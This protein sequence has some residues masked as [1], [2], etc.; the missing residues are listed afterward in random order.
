[1]AVNAAGKVRVR[2]PPS[3]TG[4]LHLG[5]ARTALF[6]W[7][8]ARKNGGEFIFRIED[9]DRERS[10]K[11]YEDQIIGSLN[12]LG[13]DWD[14]GIGKEKRDTKYRQSERTEIYRK[15]LEQ[16]LAE[17][18]AYYCY[19]SKEDLDAEK[20]AAEA[21]GRAW[22]YSGRCRDLKESPAGKEPQIIRLKV[23]EKTV[24]FHDLIRGMVKTDVTPLGDFVIAKNLDTALYNL[25]VTVDDHDM[26]VT[27]VIRGEDHI[28]NTPKQIVI[29]ESLGLNIPEYAHL[30]LVLNPDRSKLSKRFADVNVL[31][32]RDQ[33]YL[34]DA[35]LNY[36]VLLGWHPQDDREIFTL[37]ELVQEFDISRVQKSG[38]IWND[39]KLAWINKEHIKKLSTE[40]LATMLDTH[41]KEHKGRSKEFIH[42]VID[43]TRDRMHTLNDFWNYADFFFE[44]PDY[45]PELLIWKKGSRDE[46]KAVLGALGAIFTDLTAYDAK[47]L[48]EKLVP[49]VTQYGKGNVLWPLRA[50]LSGKEASPDPYTIATVLGQEKSLSRLETAIKKLA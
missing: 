10:K 20:A 36:L 13:L 38:A 1:M 30:P 47:L 29:A 9:T 18:K 2:F 4:F 34:P 31:S 41:V 43:A 24:E 49:L 12:W 25:A 17:G 22:K 16:L 5:G 21:A 46:A 19:C 45:P 27:H 44:L 37:S 11:E 32:Y 35:I 15:H 26:N 23:P 33:G 48:E 28:S 6:N 39:E 50:A 42:A 40:K 7:L 3:P 8:Y 14:E